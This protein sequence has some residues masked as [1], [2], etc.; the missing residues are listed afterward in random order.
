MAQPVPL[1]EGVEWAPRAGVDLGAWPFTVP[2]VA[3]IVEQGRLDFDGG[4]T[5]M[6]G[7]NGSGKSTLVEALAACYP[8]LGADP[9][10]GSRGST[11]DSEL[12]W[13]LRA[14]VNRMAPPDGFFLRAEAMHSYFAGQDAMDEGRGWD[15]QLLNARS[16]GESFLEVLR[17]RFVG[18]GMYFLD[19]PESALSFRSSLGLLALLDD[20]RKEGS[21]VVIA[22]HSPIL[23][24]LPGATVLEIG[25]WGIRRTTFDEL[26]LVNDWRG[27]LD[28]PNTW[29]RYL[30]E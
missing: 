9:R 23:A 30:L 1:L 8:R 22:T 4:V 27:F 15:G 7:E 5:V 29:L 19:E 25:E 18:I 10:L 12:H 28:D 3:H 20:L 24:A 6:V 13:H 2:A 16:H 14:R 21:Q 11:E 26:D 17:Q